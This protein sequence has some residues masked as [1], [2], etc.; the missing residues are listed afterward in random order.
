[1]MIP[2][3]GFYTIDADGATKVVD[4]LKPKVVIPMHYK[5][6]VVSLPLAT[7]DAFFLGKNYQWLTGNQMKLSLDQLPK[8]TT[9]YRLGYEA[10]QPPVTFTWYGQSMFT[11]K[12]TNGP[13]MLLDPV[14]ANMG[15]K[16][17]PMDGIDVVTVTHEHSDHNNVAL[18]TGSPT[19]LRGLLNNDWAKVDQVVKGVRIRTV[20]AYH[21]DTQGSARGKDAIFVYEANGMRIV[22]LGDLGHQLTP[23]QVTAIGPVDILMIPVGGGPTI[24]AAGA[25]KVV[26]AHK[27]RAVIP[28][29][30]KTPVLSINLAPV[31]AFLAGKTVRLVSGN[32]FTLSN[33]TLPISTTVILPGYEPAAPLTSA[34]VPITSSPPMTVTTSVSATLPMTLTWYGQ[35]MFT[36]KVPNGPNLMIDPV[37]PSVG[38]KVAPIDGIDV[39]TV[40]HE[41]SDHN[42]VAL[43][44]GS[45]KILRGLAN[46]DWAPVDETIKGVHLRTVGTYHDD[47]QGSAR[48]KNS[49]FVIEANGLHIVHLGDLG[50]QLTA[51]QVKAI[52]PVDVLMIPVG[53]FYT[54]D[55]DGATKVVDALKPKI[56]IP[57][58]YK[59]P[60]IMNPVLPVDNFLLGKTYQLISGNQILL[61]ASTLPKTATVLVPG[62]EPAQPVT[63]AGK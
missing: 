31:D 16:V 35:S 48:G 11:V 29:H 18:A 47:T 54:I 1:L 61:S 41:H 44:T 39:V 46:N 15:Y 5:T 21:D 27:P 26:D 60:A 58:H 10:P 7:A 38:Y 14:A 13:N 50:H 55:A 57:I 59:T 24:D 23:E 33:T 22:H 6:P 25:T 2:V 42:Y 19:I 17:T 51:D 8:S 52:G 63:S 4:A 34:S 49:V 9:V 12:V 43:A 45:P 53:G 3:G 56:V 37:A 20:G 36:L 32:Q 62:Y 30:Y 28:I 40:S